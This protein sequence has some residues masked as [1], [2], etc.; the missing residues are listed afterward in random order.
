MEGGILK[1]CWELSL[2]VGLGFGI[3]P[4]LEFDLEYDALGEEF[5]AEVACSPTCVFLLLLE[6][7]SS[8]LPNSR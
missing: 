6:Q 3:L 8:V 1:C 2:L 5:G 4:N 7:C